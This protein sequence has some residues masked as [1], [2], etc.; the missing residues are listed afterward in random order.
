MA[1]SGFRQPCTGPGIVTAGNH[2]NWSMVRKLD[3]VPGGSG[4]GDRVWVSVPA[5]R[6]FKGSLA[7]ALVVPFTHTSFYAIYVK[8][9]ALNI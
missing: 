3:T 7:L 5:V 6:G 2:L 8:S 9:G 4:T 1:G